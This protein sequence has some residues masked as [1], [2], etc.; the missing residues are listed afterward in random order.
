MVRA[1]TIKSNSAKYLCVFYAIFIRFLY[2]FLLLRIH[3]PDKEVYEVMLMF[4][5]YLLLFLLPF[6]LAAGF[7]LLLDKMRT[8]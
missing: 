6:G 4:I 2:R 1:V 3:W 8:W 7:V 5:L